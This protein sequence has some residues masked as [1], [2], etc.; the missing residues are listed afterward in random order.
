[1]SP[2]KWHPGDGTP[3][4]S[5]AVRLAGCGV[6][7]ILHRAGHP[8]DT[9]NRSP[10]PCHSSRC[11]L[12]C[13]DLGAEDASP[14]SGKR[15]GFL[16]PLTMSPSSPTLQEPTE[17]SR[18]WPTRPAPTPPPRALPSKQPWGGACPQTPA[19]EPPVLPPHLH[20]VIR[21]GEA[22]HRAQAP[23]SPAV[24]CRPSSRGLGRAGRGGLRL[25]RPCCQCPICSF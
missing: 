10:L 8:G 12:W 5:L 22:G 20:L 7:V 9:G 25:S 15:P 19:R 16:E 13:R 6:C 23:R 21:G 3:P 4:R 18:Q 2:G 1:M 11:R 14:L 24:T 17:R